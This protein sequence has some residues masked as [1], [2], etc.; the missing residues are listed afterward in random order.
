[1]STPAAPASY[2]PDFG[3]L[4]GLDPVGTAAP[5]DAAAPNAT[6]AEGPALPLALDW[7]AYDAY[8][9]GDAYAQLPRHGA[10]FGKASAVCIGSRTCQRNEAKGVMCPSFRAT[11]A[12]E[13]S[14]QHRAA[15]LKAV[16]DGELGPG[17]FSTPELQAAMDLCVSCKGCKRECPNGVDMS[18][19]RTE[20]LAQR[21]REAPMPRRE[22][23]FA[24]LPLWLNRLR[25]WPGTHRLT[26]L[27]PARSAMARWVEK[28]LGISAE[29]SLPRIAP[30]SFLDDRPASAQP[31]ESALKDVALLVDTFHNHFHP[32]TLEA[33]VD[34]LTRAGCRVHVVRPPAGEAPLCC[35]RTAL[36]GGLVDEARAQA[37]RLISALQPHL[38][39]GHPV[40][41]LEPSCLLMLRDEYLTLGLGEPARKL[42]KQALLLEEFLA[43]DADVKGD[44]KKLQLRFGPLPS[45]APATSSSTRT[46]PAASANATAAPVKVL[47]HGHCH[48]K[49][50][51]AMKAVRK[52]LGWVPGLQ[53]EFIESS[54][55]GMAG[56]FGLEAEHHAVSMQMGELSLLPTVRAA[57]PDAWLIA[58]GTSCRHQIRDGAQREARHMVHLLQ[59]SMQAAGEAP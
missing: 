51:G 59:A 36:S 42:A 12:T 53:V 6:G 56:S 19:L 33:A 44:P 3:D 7:S 47:V 28:Q 1:M 20:V 9:A 37:R 26:A 48:Q 39:A 29:R 40:L 14:T 25:R 58:N 22:R 21:W 5:C 35:G 52:V 2:V 50:F 43:R 46:D 16:L 27:R 17:A 38:D 15:T 45:D 30:R 49:A 11:G 34:V 41:G 13:H 55:C 18:L 57:A 10:G 54:C 31:T 23:L 24:D 32:E 4:P 8:G